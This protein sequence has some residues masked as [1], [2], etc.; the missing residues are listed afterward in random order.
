MKKNVLL[1]KKEFPSE[2]F[3]SETTSDNLSPQKQNRLKYSLLTFFALFAIISTSIIFFC[4]NSHSNKNS[5]IKNLY[6]FYELK[7][8]KLKHLQ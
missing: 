2:E 6:D 7:E 5:L 8:T 4:H 1:D 3:I